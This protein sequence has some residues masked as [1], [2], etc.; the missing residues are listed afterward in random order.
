MKRQFWG[1]VLALVLMLATPKPALAVE[2][3]Y[4]V[5]QT[6]QWTDP[7]LYEAVMFEAYL[8]ASQEGSPTWE[9]LAVAIE[10]TL[11]NA[12]YPC[13]FTPPS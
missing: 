6:L 10:F 13:I 11:A 12:G 2:D 3:C 9:Q 1:A 5:L 8:W 4:T 7:G